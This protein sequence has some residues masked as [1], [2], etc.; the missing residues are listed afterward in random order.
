MSTIAVGALGIAA[1]MLL[2]AFRVPVAWSMGLVGF[3]GFLLIGGP[4]A[5]LALVA[6]SP[7][8]TVGSYELTVVPLFILMGEFAVASGITA[9]LYRAAYAWL[10]RMPGGIAATT[11]GG[12]ALFAA[13]SGSSMSTAA[14]MGT[15]AL[16]EMKRYKYNP[17]LATGCLAAGGTLGILIPPSVG[18]MIYGII[19]EQ[20]IGK[21]FIAGILPGILLASLFILTVY[22]ECRRD[23]LAGPPG[24]PTTLAEKLE[25]LKGIWGMAALF[26]LVIGGLWVGLFTPVEASAVGA[27]GALL[28]VLGRGRLTPRGFL[29]SVI[30]TGKITTMIFGILIGAFVFGYFVSASKAPMALASALVSSGL[31]PYGILLAILL[32]YLV[33]GCLMEALSM[34]VITLPIVFPIVMALGFDPIW[35]G[36]VIVM[37][38]EMAQITPPIGINVYTVKGVAPDVP[39]ET[40]FRGI[41]PFV[42]AQAV[43]VAIVVAFPQ[44]ALFLPSLMR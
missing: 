17:A 32:M 37:M 26:I 5:A 8:Y 3:V 44:T 35:F 2:L 23:P 6:H 28:I 12:C 38:I 33:L 36:V 21:L 13:V 1:V 24:A 34:I 15:I 14:A 22:I 30:S 19:T 42:V 41:G 25:S 7:Y 9:E 43:A 40:I 31:P 11:I 10:A 29:N 27:L 18:F 20:S 16:P 4:K 39:L